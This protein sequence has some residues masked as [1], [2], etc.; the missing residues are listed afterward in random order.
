MLDRRTY[1]RV[2][3]SCSVHFSV[4]LTG[5]EFHVER[6]RCRGTALDISRKGLLAEVDRL[7]AAGTV[8]SLSLVP[9]DGIVRPRKMTGRGCRS[10][11]CFLIPSRGSGG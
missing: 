2:S 4:H 8:C 3:V 5:P 1:P 7:L 6:F 11:A 10:A 9:A